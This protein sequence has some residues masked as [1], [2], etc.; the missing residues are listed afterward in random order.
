MTRCA[1]G[2][3]I[4]VDRHFRGGVMKPT[5][6]DKLFKSNPATNHRLKSMPTLAGQP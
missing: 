2:V 4:E 3:E 5:T 1:F 6:A